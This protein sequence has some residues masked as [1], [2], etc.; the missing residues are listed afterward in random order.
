MVE[1]LDEA[2]DVTVTDLAGKVVY[3]MNGSTV[4]RL[5]VDLGDQAAG[6]YLLKVEG[7]TVRYTDRVMVQ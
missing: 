3:R 4:S 7:K 6:M 5:T 1:G 2:L